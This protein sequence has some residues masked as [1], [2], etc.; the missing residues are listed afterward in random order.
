M[1]VENKEFIFSQSESNRFEIN[2][3]RGNFQHIESKEIRHFALKEKPDLLIL[4]LP[5]ETKKDHY[6]VFQSGFPALHCDT[7]VYYFCSLPKL[8]INQHR[9]QIT[10]E[11]IDESNVEVLTS[12]VPVIFEDYKNHYFSNPLLDKDKIIDGYIEWAK[13]YTSGEAP[14]KISWLV[15]KSDE[16]IGFA[17]CSFNKKKKECEGV[18]YGV[19]PSHAGRGIY[20]DIIRFT[21]GYFKELGYLKMLVSTQIQN[22]SVQKVWSREGFVLMEAFDTYHISPLLSS[23]ITEPI[24][25]P[26]QVSQEEVKNFALTS[27]DYNDLHFSSEFAQS[28]GFKG[29]IAHGMIGSGFLSRYFGVEFPGSGTIILN[30]SSHYFKPIYPGEKHQWK[31][32]FPVFHEKKGFYKAVC[33]LE[34]E[35]EEIC[36]MYHFDLLKK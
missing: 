14:S 27:G 7:L 29:S 15:K 23:S 17:T 1:A 36:A 8:E 33:L 26:F 12:L 32:N 9:N 20:S 19:L 10:F 2:I 11:L 13:S 24:K 35:Q 25:I 28:K 18:L 4:R 22:F 21:Q 16:I 3:F 31:I 30:Y 6:K 34:D 5:V